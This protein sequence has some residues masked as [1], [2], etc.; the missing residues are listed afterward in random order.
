MLRAEVIAA[1]DAVDFVAINQWPTAVETIHM[2]RPHVYAKGQD[3]QDADQDVTGGISLEAQAVEDVGGQ[4]QYTQ[5]ITFSSSNLINRFYSGLP[6]EVN[7]FLDE[8][9]SRHSAGEINGYLDR[10]NDLRVLVV[11][12][13]ILDEYVYCDA[14][15]RSGKEPILAMRYLSREMYAG[16]SLAISNHLAQFCKG[17]DLAT[18]VGAIQPQKD[19]IRGH[20]DPKVEPVLLSKSESPTVVKRRYVDS[21]LLTKLFEVYEINDRPLTC[22]EDD[23]FC[24]NLESLLPQ[25][26]VVLV[27]DFGHGLLSPR[28]IKLLSEKAPFLAVNTQLNASNMGFH[29]ISKYPRA[30]YICIKESELR[31]DSRNRM[32][33]LKTL[34]ADVSRR[35]NCP[36]VM[37]TRGKMGTI[38]YRDGQGFYECPAFAQKVVDRIGAGDAVFALTTLCTATDVPAEVTG[39][40]G[41]LIGAQAVNIM[42]NSRAVDR[43][44]L[45]KS[46]TAV[47]K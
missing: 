36:T 27:C 44:G 20:L 4:I 14:L 24:A 45:V 38:L 40:I 35:L 47:L 42:G 7:H 46:I 2:L 3:Y 21:Y 16:G 11:G 1:L 29:T 15:D 6:T 5:D 13:A 28:A 43:V 26:D 30:D 41:N 9:R 8:F 18:Y 19:F 23:R 33:D 31:L 34:M 39:F 12:E 10:I 37:I 22:R 17:V 25:C 32:D